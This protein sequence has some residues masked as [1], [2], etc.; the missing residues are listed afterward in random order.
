MLAQDLSSPRKG[1]V[2]V[3]ETSIVRPGDAG[4][5]A[6]TNVEI[7][8][9]EGEKLF[10][11]KG[12][13]PNAETPATLAC[14]YQLVVEPSNVLPGCQKGDPNLVNPSGG[15][16]IIVIVDPYDDPTAASDLTT[17]QQAYFPGNPTPKFYKYY[18]SGTQPA[19]D[20][21]AA[22]EISLDI[23]WAYA[24]APNAI[25]V[26]VEG[27]D[28]TFNS[29][30]QAEDVATS[31]FSGGIRFLCLPPE[32]CPI[33]PGEISNS[34]GSLEFTAETTYDTHFEPPPITCYG[35]HGFPDFCTGGFDGL[36]IFAASGDH[37]EVSWPSV[38]PWAV[39]AGGTTINRDLTGKFTGE[40]TWYDTGSLNCPPQ[41]APCGGGG[42]PSNKIEPIPNWQFPLNNMLNG[43]RGTPDL[44]FDANP[45]S[46]V[47]VYDS[48]SY[49]YSC[50]GPPLGWITVGG[51]SL[52]S[53][54]LAGIVNAAGNFN[55]YGSVGS[56]YIS[57]NEL[58]YSELRGVKTY[59]AYFRDIKGRQTGYTNRCGQS[60]QY[61]TLY[62]W[63][64]C[65]GVGTPLTLVGK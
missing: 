51:T 10:G 39:S 2:I 20:P 14:I 3:P 59:P 21:N 34:W 41:D 38:S 58:L 32:F 47:A 6:H 25:I 36:V 60:G 28:L 48:N 57:E 18:A 9:P 23:E 63:D 17:F 37:L 24:M 64:F 55:S 30:L 15:S 46:G 26:L 33:G 53:P 27:N 4:V 65:T 5:R 49:P 29:L 11:N 56:G 31:Y 42:G 35:G 22:V 54:A 13:S 62:G 12:P 40:S 19:C 43:W 7:F 52:S 50:T 61:Q 16:G 8:V 44:S 1:T 45:A